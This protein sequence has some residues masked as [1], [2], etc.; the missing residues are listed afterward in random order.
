MGKPTKLSKPELVPSTAGK[1]AC[2]N[3]VRKVGVCAKGAEKPPAA[4]EFLRIDV[5]L[6]MSLYVLPPLALHI[7]ASV[8]CQRPFS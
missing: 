8:P 6:E 5:P 3:V 7:A 4:L 1:F 2:S